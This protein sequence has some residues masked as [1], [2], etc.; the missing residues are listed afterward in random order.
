MSVRTVT[1][2]QDAY[3][4]LASQKKQGESFSDVVRRLTRSERSLKDFVGAWS[5]VPE[6][7]M[8]EFEAWLASSDR[9][10]RSDMVELG[11]RRSR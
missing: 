8:N 7:K 4:C 10:S 9:S 3:E 11:R 5:E 2:A 1:L 6:S